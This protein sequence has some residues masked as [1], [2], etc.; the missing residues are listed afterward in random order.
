[1]RS[2]PLIPLLL[3]ALLL[4]G[5]RL[6]VAQQGALP[7]HAPEG[8][9]SVAGLRLGASR[10]ALDSALGQPD[11]IQPVSRGGQGLFY[12]ARGL[13]LAYAAAD[14]LRLIYLDTRRAGDIGGARVG[15]TRGDV[16]AR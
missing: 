5:P 14:G 6:A 9:P 15:D 4:V 16:I 2:A 13:R 3:G 1:M 8:P 7:W 12:G 11:S 10:A